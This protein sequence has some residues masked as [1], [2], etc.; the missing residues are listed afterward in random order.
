VIALLGTVAIV[1]GAALLALACYGVLRL[2]DALS[3]QHAA[4]KAATLGLGVMAV[5]VGIVHADP[6]VWVRL[7]LVLVALAATMPL[8]SHAL[9]RAAYRRARGPE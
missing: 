9:A 8:A 5:G 3:R 7:A 2:P 4:T 1:L 6:E